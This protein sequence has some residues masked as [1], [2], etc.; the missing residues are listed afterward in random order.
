MNRSRFYRAASL[1]SITSISGPV[2]LNVMPLC[3]ID[4]NAMPP[5]EICEM[6]VLRFAQMGPKVA[7][8]G[9]TIHTVNGR[10]AGPISALAICDGGGTPQSF[11]LFSCDADWNVITDTHHLSIDEALNQASFEY[12]NIHSA[13]QQP[14]HG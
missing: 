8:T 12:N 7:A 2:I 9:N 14:K 11:Y 5:R 1:R 3:E 4:M 13:W 6:P 10:P